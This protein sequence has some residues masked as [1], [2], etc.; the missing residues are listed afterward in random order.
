MTIDEYTKSINFPKMKILGEIKN[1][2]Y[3]IQKDVPDRDEGVPIVIIENK[4]KNTFDVCDA[5]LA[6][7]AV[8]L[9]LK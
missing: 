8:A 7:S 3:Y 1:F 9:F 2:K 4:K 5:D 6:L